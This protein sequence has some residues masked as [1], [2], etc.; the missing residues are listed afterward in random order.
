MEMV[1]H[2]K[3]LTAALTGLFVGFLADLAAATSH[4]YSL[5]GA[6]DGVQSQV[7]AVLV[8]VLP[9]AGGIIALFI[10]WKILKRMVRA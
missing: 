8:D 7:S 5:S 3:S 6:T 1:K 9:V 2:N 4:E 10:G